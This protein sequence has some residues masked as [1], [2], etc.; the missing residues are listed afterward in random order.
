M[1]G[2][3]GTHIVELVAGD[4]TIDTW[5]QF[6]VEHDFTS[7]ADAFDMTFGVSGWDPTNEEAPIAYRLREYAKARREIQLFVDGAQQL[8]GYLDKV[9]GG[10]DATGPTVRVTGRDVGGQVVDEPMPRGFNVEGLTF[11]ETLDRVLGKYGIEVVVGNDANRQLITKVKKSYTVNVEEKEQ[12]WDKKWFSKV[13]APF[14]FETIDG[15]TYVTAYYMAIANRKLAGQLKAKPDDTRWTWIKRLLKT[16]NTMGWFSASGQFIVGMPDYGQ[17]PMFH[18]T[19]IVEVPGAPLPAGRSPDDNNI[20]S[21]EFEEV[22]GER[23][24]AV[25]VYGRQGK[26]PIR[27]EAHD[28]ELEALGVDRPDH[29]K[30]GRIKSIEEAE[31]VAQRLLDDSRIKGTSY[32][33]QLTGFAQGP[34][35]YAFDT[36]WDVWDDDPANYVHDLMYCTRVVQEYDLD[37]GPRTTAVLQPRGCIE[38]PTS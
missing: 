5:N 22:P 13:K 16:Q 10:S 31:R 23:Y 21:G 25:Y 35:I 17:A 29:H 15:S 8:K 37:Q 4:D 20:E 2:L 11:L 7:P 6:R 3:T 38:V 36:I 32:R 1:K 34:R 24:S 18:A 28:T 27:A 9:K 26:D 30:D 19:R 14:D 12:L 33:C